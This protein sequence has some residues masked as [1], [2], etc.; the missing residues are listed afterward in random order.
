MCEPRWLRMGQPRSPID[1]STVLGGKGD[2]LLFCYCLLAS[3]R[4]LWSSLPAPG[5]SMVPSFRHPARFLDRMIGSIGSISHRTRTGLNSQH[6][7]LVSSVGLHSEVNVGEETAAAWAWNSRCDPRTPTNRGKE[8]ECPLS[9]E[10]KQ[11]I[12]INLKRG[13]HHER[14][15]ATHPQ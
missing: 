3:D 10:G 1:S 4:L 14:I 13:T 6:C 11:I 9:P 15:Y 5:R 2:I 12:I 8:V 7:G